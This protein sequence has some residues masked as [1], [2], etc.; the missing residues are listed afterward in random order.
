MYN[1]KTTRTK[2]GGGVGDLENAGM[3][4][5]TLVKELHNY[6]VGDLENAGKKK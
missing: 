5:E 1:K 6:G 2:V 3:Y 4:N